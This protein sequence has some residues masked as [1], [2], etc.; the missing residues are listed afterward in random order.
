MFCLLVWFDILLIL[1][2]FVSLLFLCI[3]T[4]LC[5]CVLTFTFYGN[6][7]YSVYTWLIS[8]S[9]FFIFVD[10]KL[11]VLYFQITKLGSSHSLRSQQNIKHVQYMFCNMLYIF[12]YFMY[13]YSFCNKFYSLIFILCAVVYCLFFICFI[14]IYCFNYVVLPIFFSFL[15]YLNQLIFY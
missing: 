8:V 15:F 11:K 9:H 5:F 14:S 13:F 7:C 10:T 12:Y 2:C 3:C 6:Y 4:F 1:L